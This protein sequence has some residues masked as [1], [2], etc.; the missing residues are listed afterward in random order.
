MVAAPE[1]ENLCGAAAATGEGAGAELGAAVENEN[2]SGAVFIAAAG[3]GAGGGS[4]RANKGAEVD[5]ASE[6]ENL[7][8]VAF[9][10]A[11][12]NPAPEKLNPPLIGAKAGAAC[13]PASEKVN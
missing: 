4:W 2:L 10:P 8:G 12:G 6:N 13:T 3:D 1:N 7:C 5:V 11:S 9:I